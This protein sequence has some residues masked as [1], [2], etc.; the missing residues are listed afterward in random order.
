MHTLLIILT[1]LAS[2]LLVFI[3]LI[4]N[5]KGG[6]L[7]SG[8]AGSNNLMGVQRT[9]DIL[10]KGTWVLVIAIMVFSLLI[11]VTSPGASTNGNDLQHQITPTTTPAAPLQ[12][13]SATPTTPQQGQK[14]ISTDST[15]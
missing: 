10:E 1:I 15:K 8:F 9:G 13:P 14:P 11:N 4:Q 5:P 12:A 7:A 6:G 2:V 3:V